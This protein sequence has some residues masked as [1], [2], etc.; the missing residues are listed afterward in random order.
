[1]H[2]QNYGSK[3]TTTKII[4]IRCD[5]EMFTSCHLAVTSWDS[6]YSK[7][8]KKTAAAAASTRN[9]IVFSWCVHACVNEMNTKWRFFMRSRCFACQQQV[10]NREIVQCV[11]LLLCAVI[12]LNFCLDT[13]IHRHHL[14]FYPPSN[15]QH[16]RTIY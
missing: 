3:W 4:H 15:I 10:A 1:M 12:Q 16:F 11:H 2:F 7:L 6:Q 5:W 13:H 9:A 8:S 14:E